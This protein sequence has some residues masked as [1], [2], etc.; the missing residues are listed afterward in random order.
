MAPLGALVVLLLPSLSF[1]VSSFDMSASAGIYRD[2]R[3][4]QHLPL[5]YTLRYSELYSQGIRTQFD[6]ILNNDLADSDWQTMTSQANVYVPLGEPST[7][8]LFRRS[9]IQL[10][11]QS[12]LGP[13]D[14]GILDGVQLPYYLTDTSGFRLYGGWSHPLDLSEPEGVPLV[15]GE[16]FANI[17]TVQTRFGS[18][19]REDGLKERS[20]WLSLSREFPGLP[21]SPGLLGKLEV[22]DDWSHRQSLFELTLNPTDGVFWSTMYSDR[23]P[24]KVLPNENYF[25]YRMLAST[26]QTT[27]EQSWAVDIGENT[28]VTASARWMAF[29]NGANGEALNESGRQQTMA[30]LWA[31]DVNRFQLPSI[32]HIESFGGELWDTGASWWHK[33]DDRAATSLEVAA[34]RF[35]KLNGIVGWAYHLRGGLEWRAAR[36]FF[37]SGIGEV[38]R[39]HYF[40][41]DVR[42]L[43][44]V[45]FF[46]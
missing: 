12:F 3:E 20:P 30:L 24:H 22:D 2:M 42:A 28:S 32:T 11:R 39:N 36:N 17:L 35:D 4:K 37:V 18:A 16:V 27:F 46:N 6:V 14:F 9:S 8:A 31:D 25:L 5:Y 1:A 41:F 26:P 10:G 21:W 38:E 40:A 19:W 33:L 13:F 45:T 29:G 44:N 43:V 34:A 15:G 23:I 7:T